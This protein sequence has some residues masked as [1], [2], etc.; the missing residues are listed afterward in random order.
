MPGCFVVVAK[1]F[2]PI[3][4]M[5]LSPYPVTLYR[6]QRLGR[7]FA[8]PIDSSSY[9]ANVCNIIAKHEGSEILDNEGGFT[10]PEASF[11]ERLKVTDRTLV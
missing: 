4:L 3:L 2:F 1:I 10:L 11:E 7:I 9:S 5:N 6:N 8:L